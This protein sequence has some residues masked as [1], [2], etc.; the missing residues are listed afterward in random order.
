[1]LKLIHLKKYFFLALF[2][3]SLVFAKS[4]LGDDGIWLHDGNAGSDNAS[5]PETPKPSEDSSGN[6]E[7]KKWRLRV[8]G[9]S[10][11]PREKN[12]ELDLF[13][14]PFG[15]SQYSHNELGLELRWLKKPVALSVE[16]MT[17]PGHERSIV[18]SFT[19]SSAPLATYSSIDIARE[20]GVPTNVGAGVGFRVRSNAWTGPGELSFGPLL[21]INGASIPF[22]QVF[23]DSLGNFKKAEEMTDEVTY[24]LVALELG[25][26]FKLP[27]GL[28]L[29]FGLRE[30]FQ[31]NLHSSDQGY[32]LSSNSSELDSYYFLTTAFMQL[33]YG[34]QF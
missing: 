20:G 32:W 18:Q 31:Y 10:K 2:S 25:C 19:E 15:F 21:G 1:M 7:S 5:T 4:L 17:V 6:R 27:L 8:K 33:G 3:F 28:F 30:N 26:R 9:K 11:M 34:V 16:Y 22:R 13:G 23:Y 12:I 14:S 24:L 29:N